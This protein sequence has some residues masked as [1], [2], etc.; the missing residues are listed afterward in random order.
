MNFSINML[1]LGLLFNQYW[2]GQE[3]IRAKLT[4]VNFQRCQSLPCRIALSIFVVGILPASVRVRCS[5][6]FLVIGPSFEGRPREGGSCAR[7]GDRVNSSRPGEEAR[8]RGEGQCQRNWDAAAE[9]LR[10]SPQGC[11]TILRL[12]LWEIYMK[13]NS[14]LVAEFVVTSNSHTLNR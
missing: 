7:D 12:S 5:L 6:L 3:I 9:G 11:T 2:R 4:G 14:E 8:A 10:R 1:C 13:Q